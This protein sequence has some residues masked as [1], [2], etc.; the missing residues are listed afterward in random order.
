M[1][2]TSKVA[3]STNYKQM[4]S[5]REVSD[6]EKWS[7]EDVADFFENKGLGE[8]RELL[9]HHRITGKVAPQL[10]DTDLKDMGI[11]IV[12]D[13][14]RFRYILKTFGRKARQVQRNKIVWSGEERVFFG[15]ADWCVGSCG[16][17]CPIDPSTYRL[18]NNHLKI[19]LVDP[20]RV[21]PV[22]LCCCAKFS[23]NNI[24]LSQVDDVDI[25]GIPAPFVQQ[26]FCCA[27]G[28][29]IIEVSTAEGDVPVIVRMGEAQM[30]S[31]NIMN[32]VE[33]A[34]MIERD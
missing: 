14:C 34:Q 32:Q 5:V 11:K 7:S 18:T 19:R 13:R 3:P 31:D 12:G 20:V 1:P 24:D 27:D 33:E 15:C 8:Y 26:C 4:D 25:E 21:G 10:T 6:F 9:V 2:P 17:L 28:K 30:V 29:E 23:V 22:R 16:G